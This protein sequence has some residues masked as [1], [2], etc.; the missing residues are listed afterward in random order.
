MI[1]E[2][3]QRER[4]GIHIKVM[5]IHLSKKPEDLKENV[6]ATLIEYC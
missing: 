5:G 3:S 1:R 6:P 4:K 2:V